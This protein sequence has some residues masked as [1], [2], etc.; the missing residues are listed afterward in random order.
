VRCSSCGQE[1]PAGFRFCG[2]CGATLAEPTR[3]LRKLV[4]VVFCDLSDST[5]LGERTDPEALRVR[6]R[7]FYEEMRT[8]LERHGGTV[9]KFIGD[10]VMAVVGLPVA[11]E[12]DALRAVRAAWEMRAAVASLGLQARI[13][14]NT[15]EA[16]AGEGD[17]IVTGDAVNV[18]A[19]LEQSAEPGEVL[20][21]AE[22]RR[23]VRDAVRVEPVQVA[24]KGKTEPVA[25]FRLLEL[26]MEAP[27]LGRQLKT[28]LVGR[29]AELEQLRQAF[30]RSVRERRCHLFTLLGA[31]GIGKSRLISE[32]LSG[33]DAIVVSGRCLSYG[34]GITFWPVVSVL[35]Q[36]GDRAAGTLARLL[37][38]ASTPNELFW[39]VRGQLEEVAR[40][41]PL[42]VFFDDVQ[43]GE[44]TFLDLIDHIADL[45][46][47]A[48][49]LILCL[50][51]PELLERRPAWGGGKLNAT[52]LLLEPLTAEESAELIARH[53]GAEPEKRERIVSAA[54][55]NPLFIEEMLALDRE[56][57]ELRIPSTVQALLQARLD[58]L[59]HDER[60]VLEGGAVEGE[61]FHRGAV[62]ELTRAPDLDSHLVGLV[63]KELIHP[64]TPML[65]GDQAFRFRH[66]LIRD[67]A[68][69]ALPKATRADLHERF[70]DWLETRGR[71]LAELDEVLG[72]HREQAA[73]YRRELER[74]DAALERRAGRNLAAAGSRAAMRSDAHGAA[75]LIRRALALLPADDR[76]RPGALLDGVAMFGELGEHDEELRLIDELER[77]PEPALRM[78]GRVARLEH[79]AFG[80]PADVVEEA[81]AVVEEALVVFGEAGDDL[82]AAHAYALAAFINWLRSR[83]V[84]TVAALDPMFTH[85]ERAGS[86]ILVGRAMLQSIGPL[87][88]GPFEPGK[89][90]AQLTRLAASESPLAKL[91]VRSVEAELARRNKRFSEALELLGQAAAV[92]HELALEIMLAINTQQRAAVMH[93]QGQ[94]DEAIATYRAAIGRLEELGQTSFRSTTLINLG[95]VLYEQGQADEASRLALEGERLGAAEDVVN[96][97]WGRGLRAHIAADRGLHK[98]AHSLAREALAYAYETD[99]PRVQAAAHRAFGYTLARANR[100]DEA[101][102][103]L[104]RALQIWQRYG[105]RSDAEKTRAVLEQLPPTGKEVGAGA[106]E[107]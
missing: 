82:G 52:T 91:A 46:R 77:A 9:E 27:A 95:E 11:H 42:V 84:A 104:E 71:E 34:E 88:W 53:G 38:G 7:G 63:R 15:G 32:F 1:N 37:E 79:R 55:G 90:R 39:N 29:R 23:L 100:P 76:D 3:E 69:D 43:W 85:A 18:A 16:V 93:D 66:L 48:Q 60:T 50:A 21:G 31:A 68:Y 41:R 92:A 28:P 44:E 8:I 17:T 51:R 26:D 14:V 58:Q 87:V 89:I 80:E 83:A 96:F 40:A 25:A 72:Y 102:T 61:I 22:T 57:G 107:A 35:K 2:S 36:L 81:E 59:A 74:P 78:H 49:L 19:R 103:E 105:H 45:S 98:E 13:G 5:A 62:V 94:L 86:R 30:E 20:I 101:R 56:V 54:D 12:D 65:V 10:A 4:T 97:A 6:L 73:R 99:F 67:A 33:L 64:A 24:A 106:G 70:A 47:G 75:N